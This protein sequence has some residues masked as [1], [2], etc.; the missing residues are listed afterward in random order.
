MH[1]RMPSFLELVVVYNRI[2][3]KSLEHALKKVS[4]YNAGTTSVIL[5]ARYGE[6]AIDM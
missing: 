3:F 1:Q 4:L 2:I 6:N 5:Y